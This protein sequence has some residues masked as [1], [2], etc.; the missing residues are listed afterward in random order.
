MSW[1]VV[2]AVIICSKL[3]ALATYAPIVIGSPPVRAPWLVA[4]ISGGAALL[5]ALFATVV[6]DRFGSADLVTAAR[7]VLGTIG[8]R[9][10]TAVAAALFTYLAAVDLRRI[11]EFIGDTALR[12]TPIWV[13]MAVFLVAVLRA[14]RAGP[15]TIGR[16]AKLVGVISVV[17]MLI[18]I[19]LA[20]SHVDMRRLYPILEG[21]ILPILHQAA[22]P[23]GVFGEAAWI[24]LLYYPLMQSPGELR[25]GVV[26]GVTVNIVVV[27]LGGTLLI[28]LFG[29]AVVSRLMYPTYSAV[30]SIEIGRYLQRLEWTMVV[31]WVGTIYIKVAVL[32]HA[33]SRCWAGALAVGRWTQYVLPVG[34]VAVVAGLYI[35]HDALDVWQGFAPE[36]FLP[37]ELALEF[38]IPAVLL[39]AGAIRARGRSR[40]RAGGGAA[41]AG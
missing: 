32:L 38:G 29:P 15:V 2:A 40:A 34:V 16:T 26:I 18:V 24:V 27:A 13:I 9:L 19:T 41:R 8:G 28:A 11:G 17:A 1:E 12:R 5:L 22:T 14:V 23:F 36:R 21:G 3:S 7:G 25:K 37:P 39:L 33:A 4:I 30:E 20:S 31:L 6:A 10:L 35:Y